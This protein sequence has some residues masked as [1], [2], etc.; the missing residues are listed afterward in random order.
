MEKLVLER[1]KMPEQFRVGQSFDDL[2]VPVRKDFFP[3][4]IFFRYIRRA[5]EMGFKC[6]LQ[7]GVSWIGHT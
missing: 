1:M 5:L 4:K 2:R 6:F 3:R 7:T